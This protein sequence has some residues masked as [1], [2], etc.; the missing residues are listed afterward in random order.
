MPVNVL[1]QKYNVICHVA[2]NRNGA[3]A[4]ASNG[5]TRI[6]CLYRGPRKSAVRGKQTNANFSPGPLSI[7]S[8]QCLAQSRYGVPQKPA[9]CT[10][11]ARGP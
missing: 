4:T 11:D 2:V 10:H 3:G 8:I 6:H 1:G 9:L 7:V 5:A